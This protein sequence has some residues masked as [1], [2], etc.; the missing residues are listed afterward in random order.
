LFPCLAIKKET[1]TDI[2]FVAAW[3]SQK[4]YWKLVT[5]P[6]PLAFG[7]ENGRQSNT[8]KER[9]HVQHCITEMKN[10]CLY[11][12]A[13]KKMESRALLNNGGCMFSVAWLEIHR[14]MIGKKERKNDAFTILPE[15]IYP[16]DAGMMCIYAK[17]NH[18]GV[19]Y[20]MSCLIGSGSIHLIIPDWS[21]A[22]SSLHTICF[23]P[24]AGVSWPPNSSMQYYLQV[25][26]WLLG[27]EYTLLQ[28]SWFTL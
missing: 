12:S 27:M 21:I 15:N 16:S 5:L 3:R 13:Y 23:V 26:D 8:K 22:S 14:S 11:N 24:T 20:R 1:L 2:M 9:M 18:V 10:R 7:G 6:Q 25:E 4:K 28:T 17:F 19:I